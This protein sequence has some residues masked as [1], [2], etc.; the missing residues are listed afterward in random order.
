MK[1]RIL[2]NEELSHLEEDFKH[3]LIVNGVHAEEWEALN[4][5][6]VDKA[7]QLVEVFS[8]T[9]LQKVYEKIEYLEFR[10]VNTCM[11]FHLC[12][13]KIELI[14]IHRKAGS[15]VDLSS[16]D[17]IHEA[18]KNDAEQLTFFKTEKPYSKNR[19]AEIHEMIEQGCVLSSSQFWTALSLSIVE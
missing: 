16:V 18:L 15:E 9:V 12:Q 6:D 8:D 3:F 5:N 4:K 19:E 14:S 13:E 17:S 11:V 1:Y 2:S 7:V 10:S